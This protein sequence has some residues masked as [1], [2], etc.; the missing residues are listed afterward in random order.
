MDYSSAETLFKNTVQKGSVFYFVEDTFETDRPHF[1]VVLN[2]DP[3]NEKILI[4]V[5]AVTLSVKVAFLYE[6]F[7]YLRE[8]MV[9][10][11]P[12]LCSFLK[13]PSIFN[14][15]SPIEKSFLVFIDKLKDG[16]LKHV[17]E[18]NQELLS[19]LRDGVL[20]S[21]LVTKECKKLLSK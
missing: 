17:G 21:P 16:K 6:K 15:N 18:V 8:T 19:K 5:C 7:K 3:K 20:A 14:C 1:F 4:L 13:H 9:D 12:S 10:V 11:T 2:D